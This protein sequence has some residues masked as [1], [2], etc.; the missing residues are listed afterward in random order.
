L[1]AI[2]THNKIFHAKEMK[3]TKI[4]KLRLGNS[5]KAFM[6]NESGTYRLLTFK[7]F[8][9]KIKERKK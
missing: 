2:I 8:T 3:I 6:E 1:K 4:Q 9:N 7:V 5:L